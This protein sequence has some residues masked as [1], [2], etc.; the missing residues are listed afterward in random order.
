MHIDKIISQA[1][2]NEENGSTVL[3]DLIPPLIREIILF[4][5][6]TLLRLSLI[7]VIKL[8]PLLPLETLK[9]DVLFKLFRLS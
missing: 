8:L 5:I 3:G 1:S 6:A 9:F 2:L 4:L 7:I